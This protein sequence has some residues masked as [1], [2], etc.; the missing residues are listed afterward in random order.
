MNF[1]MIDVMVGSHTGGIRRQAAA[2]RAS[3]RGSAAGAA[4][5]PRLPLRSRIGFVLVEAG[6]HLQSGAGRY[7]PT[8]PRSA[9]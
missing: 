2:A 1:G 3:A 5:R 9:E 7:P 8:R 6:L 4:G